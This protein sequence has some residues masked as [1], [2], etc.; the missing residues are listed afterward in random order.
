[1]LNSEKRVFETTWGGRPLSVEIGQ[2]AK[3]ANGA[4]LVR[5]GDTVVLSAAVAS[6]QAKDVD[7]FPLTVNYDE[8]MYAVG[9]VPGGFIKRE[10]RPS[11][12][13]TLTARLI[14]RPIRPMFAEGFRNEVQI[15]NVVMSVEQDCQPEMAAML[16]S[17]LALCVSDIPFNGPIAGVDVGRVNGE[18]IINPTIEQLELSDIE[19][20]VAGT[21]DAIN[22]VESGA[23]EVSEEDML[24]ALLFGHAEIKRLVAFQEEIANEIGKEKMEITLLQ[25]DADL[26]KEINDAYQARMVEAIQTEEKLAREDNIDA[27]K[28]EIKAF[29]EE[30]FAEDEEL[31]KW[32][33]EVRQILEDME[34]M[35]YV[36]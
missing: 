13:A 8:K 36:V 23:K 21:K 12:N 5:Y 29:Y 25:V 22:M 10:A 14:D 2:L 33:K 1:M 35:K 28:E 26:E 24:G 15:T 11:E 16:G 3:Q 34:K 7:F 4:V 17:S 30:K 32:M 31:A 9:K 27:L 20:T 18:Y 19:L 6:K